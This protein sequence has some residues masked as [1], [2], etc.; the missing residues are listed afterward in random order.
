MM[1]CL[2]LKSTQYLVFHQ[3]EGAFAP[4]FVALEDATAPEMT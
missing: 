2:A 4:S 1:L 3:K